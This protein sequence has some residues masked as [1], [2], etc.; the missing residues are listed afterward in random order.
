MSIPGHSIN[1]NRGRYQWCGACYALS[2]FTFIAA[3]VVGN[4]NNPG[5][6]KELQLAS[7]YLKSGD[8]AQAESVLAAASKKFPDSADVAN[9]MAWTLYLEHK[10]AQAEPYALHAVALQWKFDLVGNSVLQFD[11]LLLGGSQQ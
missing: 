2:L 10:Y 1:P 8:Y 9:E 7:S 6:K 5:P 11:M 4:R 3:I